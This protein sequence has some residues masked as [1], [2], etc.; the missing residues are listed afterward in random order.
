M[1]DH[2]AH[3]R[4][5]DRVTIR[6]TYG[7]PPTTCERTGRVNRLLIFPTHVVL[8]IGNNGEVANNDNIIRCDG[9][10]RERNEFYRKASL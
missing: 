9:C 4:G 3:I 6:T 7:I 5:N 2:I 1:T 10:A 8:N